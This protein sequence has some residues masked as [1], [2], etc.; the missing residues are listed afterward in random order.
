MDMR[1]LTVTARGLTSHDLNNGPGWAGNTFED[2]DEKQK[3]A[4]SRISQLSI[5]SR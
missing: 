4:A 3:K 5:S 2:Q 1:L